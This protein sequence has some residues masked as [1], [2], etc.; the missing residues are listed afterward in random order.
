MRKKNKKNKLGCSINLPVSESPFMPM[1]L[2]AV[3]EVIIVVA[4]II[5]APCLEA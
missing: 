2:V 4:A 5:V 3:F 1:S